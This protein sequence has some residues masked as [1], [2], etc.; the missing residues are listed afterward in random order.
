MFSP[1]P[2]TVAGIVNLFVKLKYMDELY[3]EKLWKGHEKWRGLGGYAT[4]L[5]SFH[6]WNRPCKMARYSPARKR[7]L[8]GWKCPVMGPKAERKRCA[9]LADLNRRIFFSRRRVGWCK[10]S[11]RLFKPLCIV[12]VPRLS[13]SPHRVQASKQRKNQND[14]GTQFWKNK[15]K[16]TKRSSG[17]ARS[18]TVQSE[19]L[20]M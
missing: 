4:C 3:G 17:Q 2:I 14:V 15:H 6:C 10:F 11:A 16:E 8:R 1:N 9:C 13:V 5:T 20:S 12:F 7:C 18:G 19:R